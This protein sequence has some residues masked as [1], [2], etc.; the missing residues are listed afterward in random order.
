M[1]G[2]PGKV[3]S[4]GGVLKNILLKALKHH[5]YEPAPPAHDRYKLG[6]GSVSLISRRYLVQFQSLVLT[7]PHET[8]GFCSRNS[9]SSNLGALALSVLQSR[10]RGSVIPTGST[11][12]LASRVQAPGPLYF[13]S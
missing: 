8:S 3:A 9:L 4:G 2:A 10:L 1:Q 13:P 12:Y 6:K 5:I 7:E 11:D